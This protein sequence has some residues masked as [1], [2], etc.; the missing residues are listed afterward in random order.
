MEIKGQ[1]KSV[2]DVVS[3]ENE[4]GAWKRGGFVI[5]TLEEYPRFVCMVTKNDKVDMLQPTVGR[6]VSVQFDVQS[7]EF[8]QKW[9][10][11]CVAFSFKY[12]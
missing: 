5:E 1:V 12:V 9:Y 7:H 8:A 4:K 2:L 3:G 10:T 11:S 6:V